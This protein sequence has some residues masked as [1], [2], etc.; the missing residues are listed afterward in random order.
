MAF[1]TNI[2]RGGEW[3]TQ[4]VDLQTILKGNATAKGP[5]RPRLLKPPHCGILSRTVVE[6]ELVNSVYPVRLRSS[7]YNDVAFVGDHFVQIRELRSDGQFQNIIRKNDFGSRIRAASVIGSYSINDD[8]IGGPP[9]HLQVKTEDGAS[10]ESGSSEPKSPNWPS[11]LPL[12]P[13][14]LLLVLECGDSVFLF[15]NPSANGKPEFVVS[16]FPSPRKQ[17]V[18]PG[19]HLAVDPSSRYMV[20]ACHEKF[21]VVYELESVQTIHERYMRNEPL[22]P[23]CATRPRSVQG[24]IQNAAFL[25]PRPGDDDHIILL[26]IIVRNGKSR[27]VTFEWETG[28]DLKAVFAD[29]K[30]GH[31]MPVENKLPMLLIPLTVRSAFIVI[32]PDQIAVCTE[33]LHGPPNFETIEMRTPPATV[34]YHGR[35][36]PLWTA[37]A[38]PFRLSPYFKE[39]D[40]IYLAREDGVVM[41]IEADAESAL[42]RSTL[43]D[44]FDCNIFTSFTCLFDQ[45][46]DVLVMGGDA[47]SGGMWKIP[48]RNPPELLQTLPN[49]TPVI[50]FVTTDEFSTWNQEISAKGNKMVPWSQRGLRDPDRIF[51]TSGRGA[52]GSVTEYRFGLKANIG[53]DLE[54]EIGVKRAWMFADKHLSS[55]SGFHLL[56]SLPDRTAFLHLPDDFSQA[57]E[58]DASTAPYDL[59]SPTLAVA[60]SEHLLVQITK[61]SV[62]L[63][64]LDNRRARFSHDEILKDVTQITSASDA[65]ILDDCV[66]ISTHVG[67]RFQLHTFRIDAAQLS[68]VHR[69]T[70]D[71]NG[72]ITCLSIGPGY[73]LL[74]GIWREGRPF[75][76]RSKSQDA[77]SDVLEMID[78]SERLMG[79]DLTPDDET[80]SSTIEAIANIVTVWDTI[81]LGTRSGEVISISDVAGSLSFVVD[82]FGFTTANI[83]CT[84]HSTRTEPTVL[85]SCDS[86]LV[87]LG[88][89]RTTRTD[90]GAVQFDPKHRVWPIDVSDPGGPSPH[91]D[92]GVA[93]NLL[94]NNDFTDSLLMISGPRILLAE[95]HRQPGPVHRHIPVEGTPVK[96]IYSQ[97]LKCLVAGVDRSNRPT[98]LFIDPDTGKDMGRPTDKNG[99]PVD[100]IPGLGKPDD[101]IC[102]LAEWE[103]KKEGHT[104]RYI[105][106]ATK[107]GRIL[108][109]STEVKGEPREDGLKPIRFWVRF[110]RKGFERPVYSVLGYEEGLIYCVGQTIYWDLLDT[111]E[112]K[113]RHLRSFDLG[114]PAT[115]LRMVNGKLL[116]LT[117]RDSLE[118]INQDAGDDAMTENGGLVHV[119]PRSRKAMHFIEVAGTQPDEP[120]GSILLVS[121]RDCGVDGLWVPW[122]VPGRECERVFELELPTSIRRFRR[123][124]CRPVWEQ[125]RHGPMF[126][127]LPST[128][129]DADILGV[130][131]DGS[132]YHLTLL[133]VEI[134]RLLRFIQNIASRSEEICPFTNEHENEHGHVSLP[135]TDDAFPDFEFDPEPRMDKGAGMHVDGDILR[136]C[137]EE[138]A[139][140]RLICARPSYASRFAELLDEL[141]DGR[142]TAEHASFED[143]KGRDQYFKLA[144]AILKYFLRRPVM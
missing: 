95:M 88:V 70:I 15:V 108:V 32:S 49:W 44:T 101:R 92:Y 132:M 8:D 121:D 78:L 34:N 100:F 102:D 129:D 109:V 107:D 12:P 98:L 3:V 52:T 26:L 103:Y 57:R 13:Q 1:Q 48:P 45:Y 84:R 142:Y 54:Y 71:V 10:P 19:V 29:E 122:Q 139:L 130:S 106:V 56:L 42:D 85:V 67:T 116:A 81:A 83:T 46:T 50:D 127:R 18:Y 126:G 35:D 136:R 2:L 143:E 31:R 53:L 138:K 133:N 114:S 51:S 76:A 36:K 94:S 74:V 125:E 110:A 58:P 62:T 5:K 86:S 135:G 66:A 11:A 97:S 104:W 117:T 120:L 89:N 91:V 134:W 73:T 115:A 55:P 37:W 9:A 38:R 79:A 4:T 47:G 41:F 14:M 25:H 111:A 82:K 64:A 39:R 75:L 23:V 144:Y 60:H 33:G 20:L 131:L 27:M 90:R 80:S 140:E 124:R 113:F 43:M 141:N 63:I 16:R 7:C 59:S 72:E 68:L 24:V 112:K 123:G 65:C 6:S 99:S 21:F 93:V 17:L 87:W 77:S 40:C 119:D 61:Q 96:V 28:G 118:I 69:Q 137:L 22:N 128:I 105:L 30:H